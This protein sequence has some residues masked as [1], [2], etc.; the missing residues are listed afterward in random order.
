LFY[1]LFLLS[2]WGSGWERGLQVMQLP[3]KPLT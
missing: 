1:L 3:A 2:P